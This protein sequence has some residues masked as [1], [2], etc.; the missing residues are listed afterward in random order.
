MLPLAKSVEVS[1]N[2]K[3]CSICSNI[4]FGSYMW[5][6]KGEKED[7]STICVVKM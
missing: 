7:K 5:C 3:M 4:R 6:C 2:I 1:E